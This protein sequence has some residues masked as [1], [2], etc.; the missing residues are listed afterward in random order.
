[1]G[2][3]VNNFPC[4]K[5]WEKLTGLYWPQNRW[6]DHV[7]GK[8]WSMPWTDCE[9]KGWMGEL[10][11]STWHPSRKRSV[12]MLEI[13]LGLLCSYFCWCWSANSKKAVTPP[14]RLPVLLPWC[15]AP[16]PVQGWVHIYWLVQAHTNFHWLIFL[17]QGESSYRKG[18]FCLFFVRIESNQSSRKARPV[19]STPLTMSALP[20]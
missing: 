18:C 3:R 20:R 5:I 6:K 11:L 14:L 9:Q 12:P 10:R 16:G 8:D 13:N 15:F 2:F 1:M 17:W 7:L 4:E 19:A